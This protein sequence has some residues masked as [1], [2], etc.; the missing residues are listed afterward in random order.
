ML[1]L[2]LPWWEII[3][4]TVVVYFV[5]LALLRLR[6]KLLL[7]QMSAFDLVVILV[8]ANAV[9]NAMVGAD[10]SLLAG[11]IA[12]TTVVAVNTLVSR[13]GHRAPLIGRVFVGTPTLLVQDGEF[14]VRNME[15]E[16]VTRE[17]LEMAAREHG[18]EDLAQVRAAILEVDGSISVIP[19]EGQVSHRLARR[20]RQLRQRP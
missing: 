19:R 12:A 5:V 17:E 2:S 11:V 18:I 13:F 8:I 14:L 9:Q 10:N 15:R 1:S 7:G 3:L 16:D 6:G 4:R 20:F